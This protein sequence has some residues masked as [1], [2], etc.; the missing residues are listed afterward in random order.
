MNEKPIAEII[1]ERLNQGLIEL[2][3]FPPIALKLQQMFSHDN[4]SVGDIAN[5]IQKDQSLTAYVLKVS[6]SAFYAGL[7]TIKTIREATVRL[8]MKTIMNMVIMLS[9]KQ[10]YHSKYKNF[11]LIL[12]TLWRHALATAVASRW[13]AM[14]LGLDKM[15]EEGF[16]AGLLHDIGKLLLIKIIEELQDDQT[17][18]RDIPEGVIHDIL[19][20]LHP[21]R[22]AQMMRIQNMPDIY[23][24]VIEKH[25]NEDNSGEEIIIN[26]VKLANF[27]CHKL[28]IGLKNDPG[29]MLST[30]PEAIHLMAGD[31]LLA[32]L[33]VNLE[34]YQSSM[35]S[36][37]RS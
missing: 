29:L 23:C 25:H 15:A 3:V 30:T 14:H 26:I 37:L 7:Q 31:L 22:G 19:D 17:I 21:S 20:F 10:V 35:D 6:N 18:P 34:E 16:L 12:H 36:L 24:Q 5:L 33:Q 11:A 1:E 9:Q 32:E 13:L 28:G 4:Y 27:T 2:P 8:G